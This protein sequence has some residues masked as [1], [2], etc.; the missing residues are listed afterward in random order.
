MKHKPPAP[1]SRSLPGALTSTPCTTA[2]NAAA[3]QTTRKTN[4][5]LNGKQH[6]G[7]TANLAHSPRPQRCGHDCRW[8][9]VVPASGAPTRA[10]KARHYGQATHHRAAVKGGKYVDPDM[11]AV[12]VGIRAA[13]LTSHHRPAPADTRD[14]ARRSATATRHRTPACASSSLQ[15]PFNSFSHSSTSGVASAAAAMCWLVSNG[16][17]G[18]K[19]NRCR[20]R[21]CRCRQ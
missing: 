10:G 7:T 19:A 16:G 1:L 11:C 21:S 17:G 20:R 15:H 6:G 18:Q 5:K 9:G 4:S 2:P 8:A 13:A 14:A 12:F 3:G